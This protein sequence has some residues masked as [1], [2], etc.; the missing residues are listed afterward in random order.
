[1]PP[2]VLPR[3]LTALVCLAACLLIA[4]D[5]SATA[6]DAAPDAGAEQAPPRIVALAPALGVIVRDLGLED[7]IVG[8]HTWDMALAPSIPMV[9]TH[10]DP[11]LEAI[12]RLNPTHIL[13][14][15]METRVPDALR[16][17]ADEQGWT[18]W[19]FPLLTLD[20]IAITTDELSMRFDPPPPR[21]RS[22]LDPTEHLSRPMPSARL[23]DAWSDRGEPARNAGRVL[24]L[25][26][27]DPPGAMGPGSFHHQLIERLG[28][29]P[30]LSEGGPWQE[31][32]HEDILRL[33]PDSIVL[34]RPAPVDHHAV[35][36]RAA[37]TLAEARAALGNIALLDIP[38]VR[39]GRLALI[40]HP[41]GLLP[42][43]SLAEVA[44]DVA[45]AFDA[46]ERA[47]VTAAE[48]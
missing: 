16:R 8:R 45:L 24:L 48:P 9:G 30:A 11:D 36:P 40:D 35:G 43:S 5:R 13:V 37:P 2:V 10:D 15:E 14:Q 6:T 31:L 28:A 21:D 3:I 33:A 44:D 1:M 18:V 32:D 41:L 38:A 39:D 42:A 7:R 29:Q 22:K 25:A 12:L 34:F 20:D 26:A 27:T 17:M 4:C 23:A 19:G 46:W 47:S